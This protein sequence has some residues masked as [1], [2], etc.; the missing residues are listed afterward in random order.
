MSQR[1]ALATADSVI[2]AAWQ[3]PVDALLTL[4]REGRTTDP[5]LVTVLRIRGSLLFSDAEITAHQNRSTTSPAPDTSPSSTN[6]TPSPPPATG[7]A[8]PMPKPTSA[9]TPSAP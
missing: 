5:A 2:K 7:S 3:R 1:T 9:S 6:R 4:Q 8:P